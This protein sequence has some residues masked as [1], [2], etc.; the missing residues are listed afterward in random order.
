MTT[1]ELHEKIAEIY[2]PNLCTFKSGDIVV[3]E[4]QNEQDKKGIEE[5]AIKFD[6][7]RIAITE[8]WIKNANNSFHEKILNHECD[9]II[10]TE[11]KGKK[12]IILVELKGGMKSGMGKGPLQLAGSGFKTLI[13]LMP[14]SGFDTNDYNI[15]A[16]LA[17]WKPSVTESS[18][19]YRAKQV[20]ML[21]GLKKLEYDA[22]S[23]DLILSNIEKD[24]F[25][26]DT[27]PAKP[28]YIVEE[29]P[30]IIYT[31]DNKQSSGAFNLTDALDLIQCNA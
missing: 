26:K 10:I 24:T 28:E 17:M 3:H 4:K 22:I 16:I 21:S 19:L 8:C 15:C 25:N 23:K 29:M 2:N 6:N 20:G 7:E 31:I 27:I 5:V 1:S 11:Y 9:Q 30:L 12:Y 14:I 18:T 13:N